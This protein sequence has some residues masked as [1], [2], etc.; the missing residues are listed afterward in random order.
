MFVWVLIKETAYL[1]TETELDESDLL[2][3]TVIL[4][5][6]LSDLSAVFDTNKHNIFIQRLNNIIRIKV[7]SIFT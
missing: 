1:S 3:P 7:L 6:V 4:S 5:V 2:P